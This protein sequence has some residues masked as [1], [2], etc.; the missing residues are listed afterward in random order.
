MIFHINQDFGTSF[1]RNLGDISP[2][3]CTEI[4][5]SIVQ[6]HYKDLAGVLI[7]AVLGIHRKYDR[8]KECRSTGSWNANK[9]L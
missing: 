9:F 4:L 1:L 3:S 5:T 2:Q 7:M 8:K 6:V